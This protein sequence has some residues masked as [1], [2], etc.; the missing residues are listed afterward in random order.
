MDGVGE[1]KV[2]TITCDSGAAMNTSQQLQALCGQLGV[3]VPPPPPPE[4]LSPQPVAPPPPALYQPTPGIDC[5][6]SKFEQLPLGDGQADAIITDIPWK[7]PW[8]KHAEDFAA[9]CARKLKPGGIMATLYW[10][11]NL[12]QLL[13]KLTTHLYYVWLCVSPMQG[14]IQRKHTAFVHRCCTLCVVCSNTKEPYIHRSP[15][16]LL[17][18]SWLEKEDREWH[19]HQQSLPVVQYLVEHFAAEDDLVV[20][21][22]SG[23]WTT[24]EACWRTGRADAEAV[25]AVLADNE[26]KFTEAVQAETDRRAALANETHQRFTVVAKSSNLGS[27]GHRQYVMVADDGSAWKVQRI[28]LYPWEHGQV[29]SVPLVDGEPDWCSIQGVECPHRI[30]NCPVEV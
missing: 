13:A 27:F 6:H 23:G 20:D 15:H 9:W 1:G 8:L 5:W 22:C 14:S 28:Y 16:D 21:P 25:E 10:A 19:E 7:K 30:E 11:D 18:Y 29:V 17:P 4:P 3:P 12:D 26:Q 24:M 2:E